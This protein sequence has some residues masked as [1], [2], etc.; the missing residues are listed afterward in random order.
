V[1]IKN[2]SE[3]II[4]PIDKD[5]RSYWTLSGTHEDH[6]IWRNGDDIIHGTTVG[7]DL[8]LCNGCQKCIDVCPTNV[9]EK[10]NHEGVWIVDPIRESECILCLACELVCPTEALHVIRSGGSED[11]LESLLG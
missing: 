2:E 9:F 4:V 8:R 10:Y 1:S 7:V 3:F 5:Y 6:D 11:T